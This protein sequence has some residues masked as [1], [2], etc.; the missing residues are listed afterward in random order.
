M[1]AQLEFADYFVIAVYLAFM[2][3]LG[4]WVSFART[5]RRICSWAAD[6]YDGGE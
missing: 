3:L 2:V 5:T 6:D 1:R 4:S